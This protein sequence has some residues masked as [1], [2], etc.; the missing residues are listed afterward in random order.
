MN[1]SFGI[2]ALSV[3]KNN[4]ERKY[5]P[6]LIETSIIDLEERMDAIEAWLTATNLRITNSMCSGKNFGKTDQERAE[7]IKHVIGS[8]RS[9]TFA[10]LRGRTGLSKDLLRRAV[11]LLV[12]E[13]GYGIKRHSRD[14]RERILVRL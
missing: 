14:R 13:G 7:I 12:E 11:M 8:Q 2:K 9:M 3:P 10:E 5:Y 4:V 6:K 1:D